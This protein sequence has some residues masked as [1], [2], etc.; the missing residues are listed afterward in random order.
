MNKY[1]IQDN[2]GFFLGEKAWNPEA[3]LETY[4]RSKDINNA[5]MF[6]ALCTAERAFKEID[7]DF[8]KFLKEKKLSVSFKPIYFSGLSANDDETEMFIG[9]KAADSQFPVWYLPLRRRLE[10]GCLC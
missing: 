6:G 3:S 8:K 1:V 9:G 7:R 2:K 4:Q 5:F 10:Y